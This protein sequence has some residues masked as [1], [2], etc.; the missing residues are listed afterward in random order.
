MMMR[1]QNNIFK[2]KKHFCLAAKHDIP[3]LFEPTCV[4]EALQAS[5]WRVAM[6]EEFDTLLQNATWDLVPPCSSQN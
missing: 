4:S 3:K 1:S 2:P 6:F 5:E